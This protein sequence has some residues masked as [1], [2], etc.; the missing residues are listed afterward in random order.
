MIAF[1]PLKF[2]SERLPAKN[3]KLLG[4]KPLYR[5]ALDAML[6]VS[7]LE[8][9]VVYCSESVD[10]P[11]G[12]ELALR[13]P[14]LDS[15]FVVSTELYRHF[16]RQFPSES[17]LLFHSTAPFSEPATY[18][19]LVN[20]LR[21]YDSG[22]TVRRETTMFFGADGAPLNHAGCLPARTQDFPPLLRFTH[23][24][25]SFSADLLLRHNR[26]VGFAPYFHHVTAAEAIDI[27]YPEDWDLA[28]AV[29][30]RRTEAMP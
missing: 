1:M 25:T 3:R 18:Q 8:R 21:R 17:Y 16:A 7:G 30:A 9:I 10:V 23:A 26:Y 2:N 22:L 11:E 24:A 5:W 4:G 27:D 6:Q 29:A 14:A 28:E 20:C 12:V 15:P 13:S 19:A